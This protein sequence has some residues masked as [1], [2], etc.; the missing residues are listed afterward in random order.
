MTGRSGHASRKELRRSEDRKR[1]PNRLFSVERSD[2]HA[3]ESRS[4]LTLSV[5]SFAI[6]LVGVVQPQGITTGPDGNLWFTESA[7]GAIGRMTAAGSLTQF[8]LPDVPPTASSPAGTTSTPAH[9]EAITTGPDGALWFT[10][11][12]SLIG[13]ISTDGSIT[14]FKASGL[15]AG[16]STITLGPDGALWFTGVSGDV[17]RI[18]MAGV[19]T[20]F[21]LPSVPPPADSPSGTA[22]TPATPIGITLGPDSALWFAGVPGEMG[23]ITTAGVVTEFTVPDIPVPGASSS[24]PATVVTPYAITTGPDGALWFTGA[25]NEIGR[26]TTAGVVTEFKAVAAGPPLFGAP[27]TPQAIM[28]GPDGAL[29]FAGVPGNIGRITTTGVFTEFAVP[30]TFDHAGGLTLG[31]DGNLWF[32]ESEDGVTLG[33]QPAVGEITPSGV[34]KL[35]P[36]PQGTTLDPSRGVAVDPGVITPGPDG[37]LWFTEHGAIGRVTTDGTIQQFPLTTPGASVADI[38]SGTDGALWFS[39]VIPIED[40]PATY[41]IGRI[42]TTGAI[43]E[44]PLANATDI[45]GI[46]AGPGGKIYFTEQVQN[47]VTFNQTARVGWITPQGQIKTFLLPGKN[48]DER[49]GILGNITTGPNGKVWFLDCWGGGSGHTTPAAVGS[50]TARGQ[51][52]MYQFTE[53]ESSGSYAP[54]FP[55]D[56]IAGPSGKLW[57]LGE[58]NNKPG[59]VPISTSGKLGAT[60][61][62]Q[63]Q[64]SGAINMVKVADGRVWFE[65]PNTNTHSLLGVATRSGVL[66]S[67]DLP[68]ISLGNYSNEGSGSYD[69]VHGS[70]MTL[71]PDGSLWLTN[72]PSSIVRI[73]GLDALA[74]GLDYR[75]ADHGQVYFYDDAS[76]VLAKSAQPTFAGVAS[77]G[78]KV[79]LWAQKQGQSQQVEIG[80]ARATG[81]DGTW[82]LKS[83]VKLSD[84]NY[85]VTATQNENTGSPSVLYSLEPD[86]L[87]N[88]T[89]ALVVDTSRAAKPHRGRSSQHA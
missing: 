33:Q 53:R 13:R 85:A 16:A 65:L 29:W 32:T 41:S 86:S 87:G 24:T 84:G 52:R 51:I 73:S 31:P 56:L 66:T 6:P 62:T 20:E 63:D 44:Y 89:N 11:E 42:T 78:A 7:A 1:R 49:T 74:G 36:L 5:T 15:T 21:A 27:P 79:T 19:V 3:L 14:E 58:I 67:V 75:A 46:T 25:S 30:G 88:L 10:T 38:T 83:R 61:P 39:E 28:V 45:G 26:I 60:I 50:M 47:P 76:A 22:S 40:L 80:T 9:P 12:N 8:A 69:G 2:S 64:F 71:G 77:P 34:T 57:F 17:G 48:K 37:A 54:G 43:T 4:M 59:I 23:R 55:S 35:F 72:G 82:K 81:V 70:T 68:G 18:T